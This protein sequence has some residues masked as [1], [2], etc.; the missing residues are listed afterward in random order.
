M[1]RVSWSRLAGFV[2]PQ[3]SAVGSRTLRVSACPGAT[4]S[5]NSTP[6]NKRHTNAE[7]L[8]QALDPPNV[9]PEQ[10]A[11]CR[12]GC[13]RPLRPPAAL[14]QSV[15]RY[16]PVRSLGMSTSSVPAT[17]SNSRDR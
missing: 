3:W 9:H 8:E 10:V 7:E 14:E 13:R 5:S 16:E 1:P 6:E 17:V 11:E 12:R 15:R 4:E 2:R